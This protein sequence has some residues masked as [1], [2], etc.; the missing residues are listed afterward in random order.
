MGGSKKWYTS[1]TV[2]GGV[3]AVVAGVAGQFFGVDVDADTQ[4]ALATKIPAAISALG[5]LVAIVGRIV[6]QDRVE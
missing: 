1:K 3:V 6:A 2:W 5:G 4:D